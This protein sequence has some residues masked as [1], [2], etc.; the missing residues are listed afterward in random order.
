MFLTS[1]YSVHVQYIKFCHDLQVSVHVVIAL[2]DYKKIY[3]G[4]IST[5]KC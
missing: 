4:V 1:I 2:R 5:M 3:L